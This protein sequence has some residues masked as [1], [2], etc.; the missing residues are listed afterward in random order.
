[1]WAGGQVLAP[2]LW[3]TGHSKDKDSKLHGAKKHK[4][5]SAR[6]TRKCNETRSTQRSRNHRKSRENGQVTWEARRKQ[7]ESESVGKPP[8]CPEREMHGH[9]EVKL[10]QMVK[11]QLDRRRE[12]QKDPCADGRREGRVTAADLRK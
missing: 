2:Q 11:C 6:D 12:G 10:S 9:R 1:M 7:G 8:S 5:P 4:T 3:V